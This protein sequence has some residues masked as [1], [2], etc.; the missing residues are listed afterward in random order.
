MNYRKLW[1]AL[2]LVIII[3][4][5]ILGYFGGR[6]YQTM[7]PIPDRVI[8]EDGTVL[9]TGEDIKNGQNVWQ[10]IGGQELGSIWGHGAYLAP[11]WNADWLHKE[12]LY[13]LNLW[14]KAEFKKKY[15]D[16]DEE[17]QA[18]LRSRLTTE[19]RKNTYQEDTKELVITSE[20]VKAYQHLS[21]YYAGL[22]MDNPDMAQLRD[23]YAIPKNSIK[24]L[25]RMEN[26]NA[27]FFWSTWACV[28]N[29]PGSDITYTNNWPNE[30]LV[31]NHPTGE[32]VVWSV[33]SFVML[34]AGVGALAWYFAVQR[35]KEP[36][37]EVRYP[38]KDPLL[39]LISH[40]INES[41]FKVFLGSS[42]YD[43]GSNR[44]W[45]GYGSLCRRR[46]RFLWNSA[47]GMGPVF[48]CQNLAYSIGNFVDCN[49]M[50]CDRFIHGTSCFRT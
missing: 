32:M 49:R 30:D 27:F 9:F 1:I 25:D 16:L 6:I 36:H 15:E 23:H 4:F 18:K 47:S 34:L 26:L 31:G 48:S 10:S 13:I 22:F 46:I 28:T 44:P 29:R 24:K 42:G 37:I 11:D 39:G 38:E 43:C 5:A 35:H 45:S 20:R 17:N 12:S 21:D 50:A 33:V 14:S 7:P 2:S 19:M 40:T 3:S 41:Y 8:S